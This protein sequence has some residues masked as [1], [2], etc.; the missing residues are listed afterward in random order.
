MDDKRQKL[1]RIRTQQPTF[2]RE[3]YSEEAELQDPCVPVPRASVSWCGRLAYDAFV[4]S[5]K[6]RIR[7]NTVRPTCR[8]EEVSDWSCERRSSARDP[9]FP[10]LGSGS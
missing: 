6:I 4:M 7:A 8:Y 5:D 10:G 1:E 2:C 3:G 9:L